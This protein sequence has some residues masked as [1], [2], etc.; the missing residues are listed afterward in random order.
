MSKGICCIAVGAPARREYQLFGEQLRVILPD[1]HTCSY[2][3]EPS[4]S[5]TPLH[6]SRYAKTD[7]LNW[8]PYDYTC[9][10]DVDT[11]VRSADFVV[12]F[13]LLERG[14]ELVIVPSA[15]WGSEWL[16]HVEASEREFTVQTLG[17]RALVLG[18]GM[19]F[20]AR[21]PATERFMQAW[22]EEWER[23]E[24]QD[25][26]ALLRA[27]H[28][29]PVKVFLLGSDFNRSQGAVISHEFGRVA[30]P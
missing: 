14:W 30:I 10:L 8:S 22:Q 2:E 12:G 18:G 25:M 6:Q 27:L 5:R 11:R 17:F 13:D 1:M 26:A 7:L 3:I 4:G 19:F 9:Y 29:H 20:I 16:W 21:T 28:T 24:G 23:Y 15:Q